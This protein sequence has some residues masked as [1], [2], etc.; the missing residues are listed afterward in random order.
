MGG[1]ELSSMKR[2]PSMIRICQAAVEHFAR[3]GYHGSSLNEIAT[4]VG[5]R[6]ASIYTHFHSKDELFMMVFQDALMDETNFVSD[7]FA[8]DIIN[9]QAGLR[10]CLQMKERYISSVSLR[11]LLQT[12]YLPPN[13][14]RHHIIR[15][16]RGYLSHVQNLYAQ[17]LHQQSIFNQM[18]SDILEHFSQAYLGIIDSLHVELIYSDELTDTGESFEKRRQAL[19]AILQYS[20]NTHKKMIPQ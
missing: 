5:I 1:Q 13:H 18:P 10:Y 16:Y 3:S 17:Q 12:A 8:K 4:T 19:W 20:L 7:S 9:E 14:L 2:S 6:K 11:F 15:D